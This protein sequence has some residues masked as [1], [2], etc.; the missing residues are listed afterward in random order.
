MLVFGLNQGVEG[1]TDLS[2]Y[3]HNKLSFLTFGCSRFGKAATWTFQIVSRRYL[4]EKQL[5]WEPLQT[6]SLRDSGFGPELLLFAH[7]ARAV[8]PCWNS[9]NYIWIFNSLE[10]TDSL[11]E[12]NRGVTTH[13]TTPLMLWGC[14][15]VA[16]NKVLSHLIL[17]YLI[18]VMFQPSK[19]PLFLMTTSTSLFRSE[20]HRQW[21]KQQQSAVYTLEF[22]E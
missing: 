13:F 4:T 22:N 19:K 2:M 20:Q 8:Q 5:H 6:A 12:E 10:A 15:P 3:K 7:I 1:M 11:E 17:S 16:L 9:T 14:Y 18:F 21:E